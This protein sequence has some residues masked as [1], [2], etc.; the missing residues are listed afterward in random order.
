M[1][2][3][4]RTFRSDNKEDRHTCLAAVLHVRL[5]AINQT[6]FQKRNRYNRATG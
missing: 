3:G 6:L 1:R 2:R 5:S 4:Q